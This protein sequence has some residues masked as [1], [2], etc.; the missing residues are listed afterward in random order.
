[1]IPEKYVRF[2]EEYAN[3]G[4][5]GHPDKHLAPYGH[6]GLGWRVGSAQRTMIALIPLTIH[7][8][9][10]RIARGQRRVCAHG[11]GVSVTRDLQFKGR[12]LATGPPDRENSKHSIPFV[13]GS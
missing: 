11:G 4:V 13:S 12:Y 1:M 8:S 6:R 3:V 10:H 7:P 5:C 9:S 2:V